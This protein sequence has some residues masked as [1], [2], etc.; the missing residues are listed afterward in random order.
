MQLPQTGLETWSVLKITFKKTWRERRS[1]PHTVCAGSESYS[2]LAD[3]QTHTQVITCQ[4]FLKVT[5]SHVPAPRPFSYTFI[6]K[7]PLNLVK[8][9]FSALLWFFLIGIITNHKVQKRQ[10]AFE[11]LHRV[12]RSHDNIPGLQSNPSVAS[13]AHRCRWTDY[14]PR[15]LRMFSEKHASRGNDVRGSPNRN[16]HVKGH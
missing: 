11:G 7:R 2:P 4:H 16:K 3:T 1:V 9:S 10:G 12:A 6:V 5:P 15:I 8:E 14:F 13:A